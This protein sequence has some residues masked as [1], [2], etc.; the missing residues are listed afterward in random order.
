ML[1]LAYDY[2]FEVLFRV[3]KTENSIQSD[4]FRLRLH[5][6]VTI[7]AIRV[8]FTKK[9]HPEVPWAPLGDMPLNHRPFKI[10][11]INLV[12]YIAPNSDKVHK[13]I[14]FVVDYM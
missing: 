13:Y 12:G 4:L 6:D 10:A 5:H 11:A 1:E 3:R 9:L 8:T 2:L 7:F 14:L